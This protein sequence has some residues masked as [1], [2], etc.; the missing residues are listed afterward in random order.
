MSTAKSGRRWTHPAVAEWRSGPVDAGGESN[1]HNL[2]GPQSADQVD[3][4]SL[5]RALE[6]SVSGEV[7][8][9]AGTRAI[10]SHDS[11]N[12]RQTPI[13][14]VVPRTIDDVV[15]AVKA[16]HE[17]GAPILNRGC[18]TS[19]S[20]ETT[21]VA[22]VIDHSKY[23]REIEEVNPEERYAWVQPGVIRRSRKALSDR[24]RDRPRR[25]ATWVRLSWRDVK[26]A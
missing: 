17:H 11:S 22:V 4:R 3:A 2:L 15:A 14:V 24:D 23:L 7:R 26:T 20:G 6:E 5:Q 1:G 13:G 10:Y 9:D 8:F 19:L 18:A 25:Q 12:Y 21:N 16:C